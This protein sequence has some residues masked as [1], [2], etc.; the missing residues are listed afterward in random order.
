MVKKIKKAK[1][2][3]KEISGYVFVGFF[4]LGLVGGAFYGRY[5]L[6]ALAGL[7]MGFIASALVRMKY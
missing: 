3:G 6:G 5:D 4:F 1:D 2:K 7:A